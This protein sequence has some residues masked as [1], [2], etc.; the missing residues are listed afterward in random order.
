M[1]T[2]RYPF[3]FN[4]RTNGAYFLPEDD[5]ELRA[6]VVDSSDLRFE[7]RIAVTTVK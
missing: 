2:G 4:V 7:Q 3:T 5:G 1:F 6:E